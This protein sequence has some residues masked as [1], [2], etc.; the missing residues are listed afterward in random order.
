M[1]INTFFKLN[2]ILLLNFLKLY[3]LVVR[4]LLDILLLLDKLDFHCFFS[5]T[6]SDFL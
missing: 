2:Q 3:V 4:I 6:F 5:F 1:S